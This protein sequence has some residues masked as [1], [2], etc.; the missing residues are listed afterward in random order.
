MKADN[1][2]LRNFPTIHSLRAVTADVLEVEQR[3]IDLKVAHDAG[4][5][6]DTEYAEVN[7]KLMAL[8]DMCNADNHTSDQQN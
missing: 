7:A 2:T 6:T 1:P 8:A 3:P 4:A 5:M